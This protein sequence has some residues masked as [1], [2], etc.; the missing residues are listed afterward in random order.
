DVTARFTGATRPR[1]GAALRARISLPTTE[2]LTIPR[3]AILPDEEPGWII[4]IIRDGK[5]VRTPIITGRRIGERVEVTPRPAAGGAGQPA[6]PTLAAGDQVVIMGQSQL[7]DG[8]PVRQ[9]GK[10]GGVEG[11]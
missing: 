7:R 2:A 5:A 6:T 8:A 4:F 3:S 11:R 10:E 1:A 9:E